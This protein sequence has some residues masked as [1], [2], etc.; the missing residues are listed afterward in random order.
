VTLA[1]I[2]AS[3]PKAGFCI[4]RT[5]PLEGG[6]VDNP[7]DPGGITNHG[8]SLRWALAEAKVHPETVRMLDLDHDGHVDRKDV[9]GLTADEAAEIYYACWWL[10]GPYANLVPDLI[11]WKVFDIAVNTGPNRAALILQKALYGAGCDVGRDGVIGPKTV[12]AVKGEDEKDG[13]KHLLFLVRQG[14]AYFYRG[15]CA[16]SPELGRFLSGW[17]K[18][19]AA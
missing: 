16:K 1:A 6:L 19:A 7:H 9:Q 3:D 10:R 5:L 15:L 17:L 14:Q 8:V 4:A 12:L 2:L 11:A 13:G 18:R